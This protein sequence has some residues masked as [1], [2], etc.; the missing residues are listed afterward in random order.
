MKNLS[1]VLCLAA[2]PLIAACK[3]EFVPDHKLVL[4][5][6]VKMDGLNGSMTFDFGT[7]ADWWTITSDQA[8]VHITPASGGRGAAKVK[9]SADDNPGD[10]SRFA[11]LTV[12]TDQLTETRQVIQ[13]VQNCIT[14]TPN[15][16]HVGWEGT[17]DNPVIVRIE[18]KEIEIANLAMNN[19]WK[20]IVQNPSFVLWVRPD[21]LS[22]DILSIKG[23]WLFKAPGKSYDWP[24]N[25]DP[26]PNT[27][28]RTFK[29]SVYENGG[30]AAALLTFIQEGKPE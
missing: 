16:I 24:I 7:N 18:T 8:W 12:T 5:E 11:T 9:V 15:E 29:F 28:P 10:A 22:L 21:V 27:S 26:N 6:V 4:P 23:L 25:V 19:L 20:Q 14:L 2:F 3:K 17:Q 13:R 30:T 1:L